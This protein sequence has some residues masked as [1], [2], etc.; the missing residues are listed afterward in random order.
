MATPDKSWRM[1]PANNLTKSGAEIRSRENSGMIRTVV[2]IIRLD[3]AV[4]SLSLK[5]DGL[6]KLK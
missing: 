4:S 1:M 2:C 6:L 5:I 3:R